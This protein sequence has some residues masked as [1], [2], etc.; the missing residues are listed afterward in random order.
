MNA[1]LKFLKEK[2]LSGSVMVRSGKGTGVI[3]LTEGDLT[4]AYTSD[5]RD[6]AEDAEGVLALCE[7]PEAMIEVKAADGATHPPLHVEEIVGGARSAPARPR[8]PEPGPAATLAPPPPPPPPEAAPPPMSTPPP[9]PSTP[10]PPALH[11][12][13]PMPPHPVAQP[14]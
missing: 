6:I 4:G 11:A 7:D 3:I 2:K 8:E 5:S 10:P 13:P 14:L 9:A 12:A 1:L